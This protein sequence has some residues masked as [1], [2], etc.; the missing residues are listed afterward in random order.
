MDHPFDTLTADASHGRDIILGL[1]NM[2]IRVVV[3]DEAT[4]FMTCGSSSSPEPA[5]ITVGAKFQP[6]DELGQFV[7]YWV[8]ALEVVNDFIDI[9]EDYGFEDGI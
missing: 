6:R 2:D 8:V 1:R 4:K 3:A 5:H 9:E 7:P